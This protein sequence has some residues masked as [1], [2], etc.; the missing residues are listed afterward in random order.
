MNILLYVADFA[1]AVDRNKPRSCTSDAE[2][3]MQH[4]AEIT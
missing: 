4:A 1:M 2:Q 3:E